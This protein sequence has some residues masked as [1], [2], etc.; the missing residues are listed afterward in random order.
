MYLCGSQVVYGIHGV[1]NILDTEVRTI[2]RKKVEYYVLQPLDQPDARYYIPV[3]NQTAVAKM[4]PILSK[5][6]VHAL[7]HGCEIGKQ[8][9]IADETQRKQYYKTLITSGDRAALIGMIRLLYQHKQEQLSNGKKFHISDENFLR[10]AEKLLS[11]ELSLV[12]GI[13][14]NEIGQYIENE[15]NHA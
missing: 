7:L 2:D 4:M 15:L 1:C 5:E 14:R 6:G 9:W 3:A 12:L 11:G 8:T 10:D 13:P